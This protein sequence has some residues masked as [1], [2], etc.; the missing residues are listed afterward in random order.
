MSN[1]HLCKWNICKNVRT[2]LC[3]F[4]FDYKNNNGGRGLFENFLSQNLINSICSLCNVAFIK[5]PTY[6]E[7]R[8]MRRTNIV[9]QTKYKNGGA[10]RRGGGR[11]RWATAQILFKETSQLR[12]LTKV[13]EKTKSFHQRNEVVKRNLKGAEGPSQVLI[14]KWWNEKTEG[15]I[16]EKILNILN[17]LLQ[18][19]QKSLDETSTVLDLD[20]S[21]TNHAAWW[22]HWSIKPC[23]M[24]VTRL[25]KINITGQSRRELLVRPPKWKGKSKRGWEDEGI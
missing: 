9:D 4:S 16:F 14:K 18:E 6:C 1:I 15:Q 24:W 19:E 21:K 7:R 3:L 20:S 12:G 2:W 10:R 25:W 23:N 11:G 5:C 17:D 13:G 22:C 8:R